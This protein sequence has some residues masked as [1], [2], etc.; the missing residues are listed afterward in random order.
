MFINICEHYI[1]DEPE[2]KELVDL[3]ADETGLRIPM[4]VGNLKEDNDKCKY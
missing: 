4:S 1:V 2:E 3:A